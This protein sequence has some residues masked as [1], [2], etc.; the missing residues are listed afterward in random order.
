MNQTLHPKVLEIGAN[1]AEEK[2]KNTENSADNEYDWFSSE[3]SS[4]EGD[5]F[6]MDVMFEDMRIGDDYLMEHVQNDADQNK[7]DDSEMRNRSTSVISPGYKTLLQSLS[8]IWEPTDTNPIILGQAENP[9]VT[10]PPGY[11]KEFFA[12]K[13]LTNDLSLVDDSK[14]ICSHT[15]IEN[16]IEC[17]DCEVCGCARKLTK[18]GFNGSVLELWLTCNNKHSIKWASSKKVNEV[19][20]INLQLLS[21]I[22]LSGNLFVKFALLAKFLH[23]NIPSESSFYR[24]AK[25]YVYPSVDEWW[26]QMQ[27]LLF[28]LFEGKEVVVGGDGRNDSLGHCAT[29]CT[30]SFMDTTSNLILHQEIV[31][32]RE[33]NLKS[34]NMEKLGCK[35][36]LDKL[37]ENVNLKGLVTDDHN[38]ISAMMSKI[39]FYFFYAFLFKNYARFVYLCVCR[40]F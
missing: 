37:K 40:C 28:S 38:Q 8:M 29:Y 11:Y 10:L 27:Q 5:F 15:Q 31:D 1:E 22:V 24:I 30:Y 23:L 20:V 17:I 3:D 19:Y 2:G 32:V 26:E 12:N 7:N 36:G 21:S 39:K 18:H 35:R 14:F 9:K 13:A 16:L 25:N 6:E 33:A 4:E 34:P